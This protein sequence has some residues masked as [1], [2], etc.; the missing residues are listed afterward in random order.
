[1]NANRFKVLA[2]VLSVAMATAAFSQTVTKTAQGMGH[3]GGLFDNAHF[4]QLFRNAIFW[5]AGE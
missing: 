1:M 5:G 3:H 2:V 4:V